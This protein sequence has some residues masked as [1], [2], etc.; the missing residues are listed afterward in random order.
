MSEHCYFC[1]RTG[2][3]NTFCISLLV[4]GSWVMAT[5]SVNIYN[6]LY[7]TA[8]AAVNCAQVMYFNF[9]QGTQEARAFINLKDS[10]T[11]PTGAIFKTGDPI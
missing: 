2:L 8:F 1:S 10:W 6:N 3:R 4:L 5:I 7:Q 9:S 11:I